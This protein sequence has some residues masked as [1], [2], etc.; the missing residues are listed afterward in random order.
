MFVGNH[1]STFPPVSIDREGDVDLRCAFEINHGAQVQ[2]TIIKVVGI[3]RGASI[4][5]LPDWGKCN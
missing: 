1:R 2:T 3:A 5:G 4:C